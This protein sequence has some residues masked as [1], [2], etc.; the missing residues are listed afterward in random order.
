M[1][2]IHQK[3]HKFNVVKIVKDQPV[4]K[5][6]T[7]IYITKIIIYITKISTKMIN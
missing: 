2:E 7:K 4:N 6:R 5:S 3:Q 1:D